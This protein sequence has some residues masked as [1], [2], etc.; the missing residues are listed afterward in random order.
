[1]GLRGHALMSIT[2]SENATVKSVTGS[3]RSTPTAGRFHRARIIT[4][5]EPVF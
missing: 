1:M 5:D 2:T 3:P 4:V